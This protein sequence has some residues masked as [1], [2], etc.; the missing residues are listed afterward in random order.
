MLDYRS[1]LVLESTWR[2]EFWFGWKKKRH[3]RWGP[4]VNNATNPKAKV[5]DSRIW[6]GC[7]FFFRIK[8]THSMWLR[9][10]RE[11]IVF[12]FG[13][14]CC[15]CCCCCRRSCFFLFLFLNIRPK[16]ANCHLSTSHSP[17][18]HTPRFAKKISRSRVFCPSPWRVRN[19][20]L[21]LE[22]MGSL[23]TRKPGRCQVKVD[24]GR[25][26]P[27]MDRMG[28]FLFERFERCFIPLMWPFGR[29]FDWISLKK[30][31][32]FLICQGLLSDFFL[33]LQEVRILLLTATPLACLWHSEVAFFGSFLFMFFSS[34]F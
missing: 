9:N 33:W 29:R 23:G 31:G 32:L 14:C 8:M 13:C 11:V 18:A 19:T 20:P 27:S 25:G 26:I 28:I 34:F 5:D 10:V 22:I 15:C 21:R 7:V 30:I 4:L 2:V 24:H 17:L 6:S 12:F 1:V 16:L 3:R